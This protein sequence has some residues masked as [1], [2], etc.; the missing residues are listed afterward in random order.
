M[1]KI[2]K[3]ARAFLKGGSL[4]TSGALSRGNV[5]RKLVGHSC[6]FEDFRQ[7]LPE[8]RRDL[9]LSQEQNERIWLDA[10]GGPIRYGYAYGLPQR[11]FR[12]FHSELE[13]FG[14]FPDDESRETILTLKQQIAELSSEAKASQARERQRDIQY[15]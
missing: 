11:T 4:H 1:R 6:D 10:V 7:T 5:R 9:P 3:K 14:S 2:G 13:G 12:E 15:A 8:D